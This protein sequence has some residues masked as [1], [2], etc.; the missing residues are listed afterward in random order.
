MLL[1]QTAT[2]AI[3]LLLAV[4]ILLA[5][6]VILI[7]FVRNFRLWMQ[8]YMSGTPVTVFEIL[9]MRCRRIDVNAVL[10]ALIMARQADLCPTC[11]GRFHAYLPKMLEAGQRRQ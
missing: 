5:N 4:L 1:A 7:V 2:T 9:G 3:V 11:G 10:K 8:A 6:V